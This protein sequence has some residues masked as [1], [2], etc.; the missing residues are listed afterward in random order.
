MSSESS[1]SSE[2][3]P[4]TESGTG[5]Q[6]APRRLDLAAVRVLVEPLVAAHGLSLFDL[7]WT[8]GPTGMIL[9][10]IIEREDAAPPD[11]P[12][13][14]PAPV[15]P[16]VAGVTLEDC[17]SVSRDLSTALD[18][19][20]LIHQRYNLEVSSPGLDR[21]LRTP[22]DFQRQVG[23]LAKLKL[24]EP[25]ADGQQVLRGI[26][27]EVV[28]DTVVIVVDGNRHDVPLDNIHHAKLVFEFGGQQKQKSQAR[29]R[30]SSPGRQRKR[31]GS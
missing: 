15:A 1:P 28:G 26:L 3:T 23:R 13:A 27:S 14:E 11:A 16:A 10:A 17:V 7:E 5:A 24:K 25:A 30:K 6:P 2:P 9:R 21:P 4:P 19:V 20:E 18:A 31:T 8:T 29:R 22:R 12:S